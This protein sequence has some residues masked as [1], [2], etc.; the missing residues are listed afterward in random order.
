MAEVTL[1]VSPKGCAEALQV[2]D[3]VDCLSRPIPAEENTA[4]GTQETVHS[5]QFPRLHPSR[6]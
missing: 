2:E 5:S 1:D 4:S 3:R 6:G